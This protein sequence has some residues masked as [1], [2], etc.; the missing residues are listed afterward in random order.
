LIR[1]SS[2]GSRTPA[3]VDAAKATM[4]RAKT[5]RLSS[6]RKLSAVMKQPTQTP[7]RRVSMF[8]NAFPA[9]SARRSVTPHS[10]S[11]LPSMNMP[12]SGADLGTRRMMMMAP[13]IGKRS[14]S[15]LSPD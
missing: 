12:I 9:V 7:R 14:F 8:M 1:R 11:R 6:L 15:F 13:T 10:L 3:A 4:P 5:M 2:L